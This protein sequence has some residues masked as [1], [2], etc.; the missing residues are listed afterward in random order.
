M[1]QNAVVV[2]TGQRAD[3]LSDLLLHVGFGAASAEERPPRIDALDPSL[4]A[5]VQGLLEEFGGDPREGPPLRPGAWDLVFDG[6]IVVELDEE[7]H[8]NRYRSVTLRAGWA[9]VLP[10][11]D[12][13]LELCR[14]R[15][16]DCL[17]AAKWGKRWTN[18]SCER[19]FGTASA[20]GNFE[21]GGAPRWKQRALYD[22]MKD[23]AVLS[24]QGI[25][26][27]RL[28]THDVVGT[29]RL[30]DVLRGKADCDLDA[31]GQLVAERTLVG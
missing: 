1:G 23:A 6:R 20:P 7:L 19:L 4:R 14:E 21:N 24:G 27:I 25:S 16:P 17:A 5:E 11:Q 28:S 26:L 3:A 9:D 10:W 31:L 18:P 30:D 12:S 13:Y 15:E 8:F 2:T 29:A 22:A